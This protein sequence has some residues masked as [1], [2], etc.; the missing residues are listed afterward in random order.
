[1]DEIRN[2]RIGADVDGEYAEYQDVGDE[3]CQQ[4]R[5]FFSQDEKGNQDQVYLNEYDGAHPG[6]EG[7]LR[8]H[9]YD[10]PEIDGD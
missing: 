9:E 4:D 5:Q 3:V 8:I 10:Y 2:L 1:V 6:E 7:L